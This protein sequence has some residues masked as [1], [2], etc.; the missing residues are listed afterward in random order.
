M[1]SVDYSNKLGTTFHRSFA[2]NRPAINQILRLSADADP[3]SEKCLSQ[4]DI[5]EDTTL[6]TQYVSSMPRYAQ[7]AGL[8]TSGNCLTKLGGYVFRYDPYM[9]RLETQ[10]LMHYHLS[11]LH[12]YGPLYW[13]EIVRSLFRAGNRLIRDDIDYAIQKTGE[14]LDVSISPRSAKQTGT[15]FVGTYTKSDGFEKLG[16]FESI[17]GSNAFQVYSSS[18]L[19]YWVFAY[20]L[21]DYWAVNYEGRLS[22]NLDELTV[23]TGLASLFLLDNARL[24]QI[25]NELQQAGI[26]DIYRSAQPYQLLLLNHDQN[27]PLE[28]IY[29]PI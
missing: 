23:E 13:Y 6:G 28:K 27:I 2:L 16:I 17:E 22:V 15:A 1:S 19:S 21:M 20:A 8:L 25:L 3:S 12:G 11:V 29:G 7:G 24:N 26:V 5:R 18:L 14:K 10:W 4:K 9:D